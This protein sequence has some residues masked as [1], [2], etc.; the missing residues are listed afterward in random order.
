MVMLTTLEDAT[1]IL[2]CF[3]LS[4]LFLL[5]LQH[6]WPGSRRRI[7]ND[8]IGWQVSILGTTYA[9]I[10]GFMLYAVWTAFQSAEINADSEANCIVNVFRLADGLPAE[11]R[12]QVHQIA[13]MYANVVL[14]QEWPEMSRGEPKLAGQPLVEKL[15]ATVV[16]AKPVTF[17]EQTSMNLTLTEISNMTQYRRVREVES[18]SRLPDILWI[19]MILGGGITTL[20]F[21]LFGT[22]NF[23]L[24]AV[25]VLSLTLLISFTLVTIADFDRPFQGV[26][27]V[28]P[29]G[30]ERARN[31]LAD[32]PMDP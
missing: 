16:H 29:L 23:K 20:S 8:V 32:L 18:E 9:V 25:Q 13:R 28:R 27:H 5:I 3:L 24:H 4:L 10:V 14:D 26:V 7:N 12:S 11:E 6:F 30:F 17:A 22:E 1:I 21:F 15:W 31:T 2:I 19:L